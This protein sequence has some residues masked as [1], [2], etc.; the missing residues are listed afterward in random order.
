MELSTI[1]HPSTTRRPVAT[2]IATPT[3]DPLLRTEEATAADA[4]AAEQP[5]DPSNPGQ[6]AALSYEMFMSAWSVGE[7]LARSFY[8]IETHANLQRHGGIFDVD[9]EV[10]VP[11]GVQV[12]VNGFRSMHHFV[13]QFKLDVWVT[14]SC[15]KTVEEHLK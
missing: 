14:C 15:F 5:A 12:P 2:T 13:A 7:R 3:T 8:K 11:D 10:F 9:S 1:C 6:S 4:A